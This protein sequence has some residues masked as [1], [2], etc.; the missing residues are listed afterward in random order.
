MRESKGDT[1]NEILKRMFH[2]L[3]NLEKK[4]KNL[5][6]YKRTTK[7]VY[8]KHKAFLKYAKRSI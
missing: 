8:N 6:S 4:T 1:I 2:N 3:V 5:V 7:T